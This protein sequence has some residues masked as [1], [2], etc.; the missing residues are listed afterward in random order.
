MEAEERLKLAQQARETARNQ[1]EDLTE[2]EAVALAV[3]V[4]R[5][6]VKRLSRKR[7]ARR[8][9]AHARPA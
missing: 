9:T 5:T 7:K 1:N 2:E 6:A 4:Q 3:Q 8:T